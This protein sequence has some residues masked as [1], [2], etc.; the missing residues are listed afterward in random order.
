MAYLS[1]VLIK[2]YEIPEK[3]VVSEKTKRK[4]KAIEFVKEMAK[5]PGVTKKDLEKAASLLIKGQGETEK[6]SGAIKR[7]GDLL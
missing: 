6:R 4:N 3:M 7:L 5:E 1:T 2:E